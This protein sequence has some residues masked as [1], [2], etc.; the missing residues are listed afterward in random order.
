MQVIW[1]EASLL[2]R[3]V[4]YRRIRN[5][6]PASALRTDKG[7]EREVEIL[8]R[9]PFLGRIGKVPDTREL[10]IR[11]TP[12]VA[13]Y[14]VRNSTILVLRVLHGAQDWPGRTRS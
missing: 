6:N 7:I 9:M 5:D 14:T 10:V 11:R 13:V 3:E 4:I 12:Y 1:T 2:D 8:L